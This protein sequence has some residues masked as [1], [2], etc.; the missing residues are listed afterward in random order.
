[1][2]ED[3]KIGTNTS[4]NKK[5]LRV[6]L[7]SN[8]N[9]SCIFCHNEGIDKQYQISI[10]KVN[11]EIGVNQLVNV[12]NTFVQD[13]YSDVTITGGEPL[14]KKKYIYAIIDSL[15]TLNT[16]LPEITIVTNGAL[17]NEEF[18][19]I[20]KQYPRIKMNVSLHSFNNETYQLITR[21]KHNGSTIEDIIKNI[22]LLISR[23][24]KTKINYVLLKGLNEDSTQILNAIE[25]SREL[26]VAS[27]K[28][29]E[30]IVTDINED[31]LKYYYEVKSIK[32]LLG[33]KISRVRSDDRKEEYKLL[34]DPTDFKIET[35][36]CGCKVGCKKCLL[37]RPVVIDENLNYYPCFV[38]N[39]SIKI[40]IENYKAQIEK[41]REKIIRFAEEYK[42]KA[43]ILNNEPSFERNRNEIYFEMS[44]K[45]YVEFQNTH[46]NSN[47][48][49]TRYINKLYHVYTPETADNKWKAY[50]IVIGITED[51]NSNEA[52][53]VK[54]LNNYIYN[55]T[56]G[57]VVTKKSF[58]K[59]DDFLRVGTYNELK[60]QLE[61]L[62]YKEKMGYSISGF[63]YVDPGKLRFSILELFYKDNRKKNVVCFFPD[64][65]N[66][67]SI[68][69]YVTMYNLKPIPQAF[70][71][72]IEE[73]TL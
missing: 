67:D 56:K 20:I 46:K 31:V 32:L 53:L 19:N 66:I 13:G 3:I 25:S 62:N 73:L 22:K 49:R 2:P 5:E 35:V 18:A 11:D 33:D 71:K 48:M 61:N 54:T 58:A 12:I 23:G 52:G 36:K 27:I 72:W 30:L 9:Y 21:Q 26:G 29:I 59:P 50:E 6:S 51:K 41:G 68:D 14:L 40:N 64:D 39:E 1:M 7:T 17:I 37:Y 69:K 15:K 45:D 60:E 28:F 43:P 42:D 44:D 55:K 63:Y 10:S 8:C 65:N 16:E 34:N 38:D 57:F 47:I 70:L 4:F 24:I